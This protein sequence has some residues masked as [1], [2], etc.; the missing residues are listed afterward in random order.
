V[1]RTSTS[2]DSTDAG[3]SSKSAK[4]STEKQH[5]HHTPV[6]SPKGN[7]SCRSVTL[8]TVTWLDTVLY[9][10]ACLVIVLHC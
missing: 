5:A 4:S 6:T 7:S 3:A 8:L 10:T 2:S 9:T 1:T